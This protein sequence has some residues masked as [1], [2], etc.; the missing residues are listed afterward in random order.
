MTKTLQE[1]KFVGV[2]RKCLINLL[3]LFI[4]KLLEVYVS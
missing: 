2:S 1:Q 3:M 4:L